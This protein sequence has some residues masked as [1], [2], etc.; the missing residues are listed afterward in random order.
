MSRYVTVR[1]VDQ[2]EWGVK[3]MGCRAKLKGYLWQLQ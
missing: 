3:L 1:N 2:Q